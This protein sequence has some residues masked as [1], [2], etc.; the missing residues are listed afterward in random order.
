V[1]ASII[2]D[3][4]TARGIPILSFVGRLDE[5]SC[6]PV[7]K[8]IFAFCQKNKEFSG[9][10]FDFLK[11]LSLNSDSISEIVKIN[12]HLSRKN[13]SIVIISPNPSVLEILE[14]LGVGRKF[15]FFLI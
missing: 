8:D 6:I 11:L 7:C 15:Q 1:N 2:I 13:K 10:I 5:Q 9:L 4:K 12:R 3:T 14:M